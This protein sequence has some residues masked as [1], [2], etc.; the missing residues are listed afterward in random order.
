MLMLSGCETAA[1]VLDAAMQS[2]RPTMSIRGARFDSLTAERIVARFDVAVTNP[3]AFPLPLAETRIAVAAGDGETIAAGELDAAATI[4]PKQ[5]AVV[6]LPVS[7]AF[8]PLL[9]AV[10]GLKPGEAAPYQ[11]SVR[12]TAR[13][14]GGLP[15]VQL[16]R[17]FEGE[18][19]IPAPPRPALK[20]VTWKELTF[21]RAVAEVAV[22][23]DNPNRFPIAFDGLDLQLEFA[24]QRVGKLD[25]VRRVELPPGETREL[26]LPLTFEPVR[27]GLAGIALLREREA[28]YALRGDV[29]FETPYGSLRAPIARTGVTPMSR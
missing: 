17:M 13:P 9:S 10:R 6:E 3:Y 25:A 5:T 21:N 22:T 16:N 1:A 4:E 15:P 27:L 29:A 24:D 23:I 7:V 14:G 11:A 26:T 8:A 19:P 20:G 2:E 18:I 12:M 28:S